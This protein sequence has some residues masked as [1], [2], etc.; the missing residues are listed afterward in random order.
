MTIISRLLL[1]GHSQR[2]AEV[3]GG[4]AL[5]QMGLSFLRDRVID[6]IRDGLEMQPIVPVLGQHLVLMVDDFI[7]RIVAPLLIELPLPHLG[8]VQIRLVIVHHRGIIL[9]ALLHL[10]SKLRVL[11]GDADLLLQS[12]LLIL[13]LAEAIF[14]QEGLYNETHINSDQTSITYC[15]FLTYLDLLLLEHQFLLEFS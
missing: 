14:E 3:S 9:T 10:V 2:Q 13:E 12:N 15:V 11:V 4:P 5:L 1:F 6:A 7:R 8:R